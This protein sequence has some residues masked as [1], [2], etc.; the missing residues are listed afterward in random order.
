MRVL[1]TGIVYTIDDDLSRVAD[2]D[3]VGI[4]KQLD[5]DAGKLPDLGTFEHHRAWLSR[6]V[7]ELNR[8][9]AGLKPGTPIAK[10]DWHLRDLERL[11]RVVACASTTLLPKP[12]AT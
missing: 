2:V 3:L 6:A 12:T 4:Q 10:S 9:T 7:I 11:R 1:M 8:R 5:H